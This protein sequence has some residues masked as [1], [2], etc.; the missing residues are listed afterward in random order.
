MFDTLFPDYSEH[1]SADLSKEAYQKAAP[2]SPKEWVVY[3][4][5]GRPGGLPE[6]TV[7]AL[8][9]SAVLKGMMYLV[10][11]P[12]IITENLK[13]QIAY[14]FPWI[15]TSIE[16]ITEMAFYKAAAKRL[17]ITLDEEHGYFVRYNERNDDMDYIRVCGDTPEELV[18]EFEAFL[19]SSNCNIPREEDR[20][21]PSSE[22]FSSYETDFDLEERAFSKLP[23]KEHSK[24]FWQKDRPEKKEIEP[25]CYK[26]TSSIDKEEFLNIYTL[27]DT[28][29]DK[30]LPK[31]IKKIEKKTHELI[32]TLLMNNFSRDV[33]M[34]W[35]YENVIISD[36]VITPAFKIILPQYH[37]KEI[38]LTPLEKTIWLFYIKHPEG[39]SF[40][41]LPS[42]EK[43]VMSIYEKVAKRDDIEGMKA[44]IRDLCDPYK[45]SISQKVAKV[46]GAFVSVIPDEIAKNYYISGPIGFEKKIPI[47]REKVKIEANI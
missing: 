26:E 13:A 36:I 28:P 16:D 42:H 33:I 15:D 35:L 5:Q 20:F 27:F 3:Y 12:D 24:I 32:K 37:N 45:D 43:E 25:S 10:H 21:S 2:F 19:S 4:I 1:R 17:G 14:N 11:I 29:A 39:I 9:I 47:D 41:D 31:D 40:K 23:S 7:K 34:G 30:K 22:S 46:R 38:K 18:P 44:S 6:E 8:R